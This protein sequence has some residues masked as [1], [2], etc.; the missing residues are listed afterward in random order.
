MS[1]LVLFAAVGGACALLGAPAVAQTEVT[2]PAMV[3][4]ATAI[5]TPPSE[6]GSDVSVITADDIERNQWRTLPDALRSVP[7]IQV[8]QS[9]GPGSTAAVFIRGAN[10]NQTKVLIDG[11]D[12]TD[13]SSPN[14]AFDFSQV[15]IADVA[16]IEILRGPQSGLY[17]SDAIGGVILIETKRGSGPPHLTGSLEGGSFD[18]FNQGAGV[19]GGGTNYNYAV[20]LQHVR[21][22]DTPVTPLELLPPGRVRNDDM[23][24]NVNLSTRLGVDFSPMFGADWVARYTDSTLRFTGPDALDFTE[25]AAEQS[26]QTE[27]QF[28]TRGEGRVTLL[29]G[30]FD[31]RFGVAYTDDETRQ[32]DPTAPEIGDNPVTDTIG[33]RLKEDWKGKYLL[34]PEETLLF[35]ADAEQDSIVASPVTASNGDQGVFAEWQGRIVNRL[36][37]SASVRYDHND[38]F[39]SALT[40][41]VAPTYTVADWGTQLKASAGTGFKAPTLN[42]LFVSYPAFDFFANP[43]LQPERSLGFDAGFEQPVWNNRVRFGA[44][45]FHNDISDL[46]D[47]N[48]SFTSLINVGHAT[49]QGAETFATF[50]ATERLDLRLD[51]TYTLAM[52]DETGQQLLRR[53]KHKVSITTAWRPFDRVTLAMTAIYVDSREDV[54][55]SG[56]SSAVAKP[57]YLVNLDGSYR[58]TPSVALFAR[59]ENLLNQHYQDVVGFLRPGLGVF[60]GVRVSFD[61]KSLP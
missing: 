36:Y 33:H 59:V 12:V 15:L 3:V 54:S 14:G 19:S 21:T 39:G 22:G 32:F 57:Y 46:I 7:G 38:Q 13:P 31:N 47:Y 51:Y 4:S 29:G 37:G 26:T 58:L 17:G 45:Y 18:T 56:L 49:T 34:A 35:G 23:D 20:N 44:T 61:A 60:A 16:R 53:P 30:A 27:H 10:A 9:G 48:D 11:I 41:H 25:P 52:D 6:L 50:K 28:Y 42:Q 5:P 40:W 55:Y 24:D 1:R 2:L 8:E 43:N